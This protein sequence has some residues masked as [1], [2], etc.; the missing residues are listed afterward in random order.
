MILYDF[1][2]DHWNWPSVHADIE[3]NTNDRNIRRTEYMRITR[4]NKLKHETNSL[5]FNQSTKSFHLQIQSKK[6]QS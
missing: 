3:I 6:S 2:N 5:G 1:L 4:M